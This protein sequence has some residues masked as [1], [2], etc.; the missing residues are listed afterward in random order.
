LKNSH[1]NRS[2]QIVKRIFQ[3]QEVCRN[4]QVRS[5]L[6]DGALLG[7]IR[8]HEIISWDWDCEIAFID[9]GLDEHQFLSI[10]TD[11]SLIGLRILSVNYNGHRKINCYDIEIK[12]FRFSLIGLTAHNEFYIRPRFRYPRIYM[13][14]TPSKYNCGDGLVEI[15]NEPEKFLTFVYG[16]W[17]TPNKSRS[18]RKYLS[19][20]VFRYSLFFDFFLRLLHKIQRIFDDSIRLFLSDRFF[21]RETLFKLQ[22]EH[23]SKHHTQFLQIGSSDGKEVDLIIKSSE[24]LEKFVVVEPV[25]VNIVAIKDSI[26]QN[27]EKL[28]TVKVELKQ[29]AVVTSNYAMED[30]ELFYPLNSTNLTST[31]MVAESKSLVTKAIRFGS[32]LEKFDTEK[33]LLICMDIEG[34]EVEL[35]AEEELLE[36]K[37][38]SILFELHQLAYDIEKFEKI[39]NKLISQK[40]QVKSLESTGYIVTVRYYK[41]NFIELGRAGNRALY[42]VKTLD[43]VKSLIKPSFY[44]SPIKPFFNYRIARSITISNIAEY[45][46]IN[47]KVGTNCFLRLNYKLVDYL[48][49]FKSTIF[50]IVNK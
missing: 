16:N 13:D 50:Q 49:R 41:S 7:L 26:E 40:F 25:P 22:L 14:T 4:N 46:A 2:D 38:I 33:S 42:K 43:D 35:L 36:F 5:I 19:R 30:V 39:L 20:E 8:D 9:N 34:Q 10:I 21:G 44:L 23:L 47:I 45:D 31:R 18:E 37:R 27:K 3:I 15:P 12:N 28:T 1:S 24:Y 29:G 17:K 6:I 32:L 11:L 48:I